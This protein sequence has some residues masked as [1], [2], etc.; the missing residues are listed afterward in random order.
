MSTPLSFDFA[1]IKFNVIELGQPALITISNSQNIAGSY[2]KV[3]LDKATVNLNAQ[4]FHARGD[5]TKSTFS[6]K[7][8]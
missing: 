3:S 1:T 2:D 7:G 5:G 4:S 6:G 8:L